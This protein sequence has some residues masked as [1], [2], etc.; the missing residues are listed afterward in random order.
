MAGGG[1]RLARRKFPNLNNLN[2]G[3][4]QR[5]WVGAAA[6]AT[7]C[8]RAAEC[9][10][11]AAAEEERAMVEAGRAA[12]RGRDGREVVATAGGRGCCCFG[13]GLGPADACING[14]MGRQQ[15]PNPHTQVAD[16]RPGVSG[17][18]SGG[19][20]GSAGAG[21]GRLRAGCALRPATSGKLM[22]GVQEEGGCRGTS[23]EAIIRN[24]MMCSQCAPFELAE[25][26]RKKVLV[27]PNVATRR[28]CK[29]C[30]L[31]SHCSIRRNGGE[32]GTAVLLRLGLRRR[33]GACLRA[34]AACH[35]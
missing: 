29:S 18:A 21:W 28:C 35:F 12:R 20:M 5:R 17:G 10:S 33:E 9:C 22:P 4:S 30:T 2:V 32:H 16:Q 19:A 34:A 3:G 31:E 7:C 6:W 1:G 25:Q 13:C 23:E 27:L 14:L 15:G 26:A 11:A 8:T 24:I